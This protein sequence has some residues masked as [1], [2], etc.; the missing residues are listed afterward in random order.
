MNPD[1]NTFITRP[2]SSATFQ[3]SSNLWQFLKM[4]FFFRRM[5]WCTRVDQLWITSFIRKL[6]TPNGRHKRCNINI[7]T[8]DVIISL[9]ARFTL[10]YLCIVPFMF[11]GTMTE[12]MTD[13]AT[14]ITCRRIAWRVAWTITG[15]MSHITASKT[16]PIAWRIS[17]KGPRQCWICSTQLAG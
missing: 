6:N 7:F 5:T 13:V 9:W 16:W 10:S 1:S 4:C 15:N 2:S 17:I 12:N 11:P 14:S 8:I 3:G